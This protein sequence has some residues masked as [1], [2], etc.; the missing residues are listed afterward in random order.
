V[1]ER[2]DIQNNKINFRR[3]TA[4]SILCFS[5]RPDQKIAA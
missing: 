3:P 1:I 4:P 2:A 5:D